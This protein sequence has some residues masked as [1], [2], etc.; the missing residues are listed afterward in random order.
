MKF[1]SFFTLVISIIISIISNLAFAGSVTFDLTIINNTSRTWNAMTNFAVDNIGPIVEKN[2]GSANW[3]LSVD[4]RQ[5]TGFDLYY[6]ASSM[7]VSCLSTNGAGAFAL[8]PAI[9]QGDKI[10]I[11]VTPGDNR[12]V[13]SCS[14]SACD[15]GFSAIKGKR[16]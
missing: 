4:D 16:Q 1:K 8:N 15:V 7:A 5:L 2:G 9:Y 11:T 13:C 3:L 6:S 10:T 12:P 14:G